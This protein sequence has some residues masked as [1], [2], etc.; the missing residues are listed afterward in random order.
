LNNDQFIDDFARI[1]FCQIYQTYHLNEFEWKKVRSALREQI[2]QDAPTYPSSLFLDR[3]ER[4]TTY[5]FKMGRLQMEPS[6]ILDDV[7]ELRLTPLED[8]KA[9]NSNLTNIVEDFI[10]DLNKSLNINGI[11]MNE[12]EAS[13]VVSGLFDDTDPREGIIKR[14]GYGRYF[15]TLTRPVKPPPEMRNTILFAGNIDR[16]TFYEDATYQKPFWSGIDSIPDYHNSTD[17]QENISF[18]GVNTTGEQ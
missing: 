12:N 17:V 15:I 16:V 1:S 6:S 13:A 4:F 14:H 11:K 10:V 8:R 18:K 9:C 2:Q 5:D 7:S 3:I